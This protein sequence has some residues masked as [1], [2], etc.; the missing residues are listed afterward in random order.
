VSIDG[1]WAYLNGDFPDD[2]DE[3]DD[4]ELAS[5]EDLDKMSRKELTTECQQL[6]DEVNMMVDAALA[7]DESWNRTLAEIRTLPEREVAK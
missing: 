3:S 5:L 6:R 4:D 7:G 2:D 1:L